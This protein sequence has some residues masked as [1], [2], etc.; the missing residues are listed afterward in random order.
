[1][2]GGGKGTNSGFEAGEESI[3]RKGGGVSPAEISAGCFTGGGRTSSWSV[4]FRAGGKEVDEFSLATC[5]MC[6]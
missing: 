3:W 6:K 2:F 1:L 5:V 4:P